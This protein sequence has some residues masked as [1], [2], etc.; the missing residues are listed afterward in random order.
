MADDNLKDQ[1]AAFEFFREKY[2]TQEAFTKGDL[3]AQTSR[4]FSAFAIDFY[5]TGQ[6]RLSGPTRRSRKM[7]GVTN[8]MP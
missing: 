5:M 1:R 8:R 2:R 3:Q 7:R 4:R 6:R